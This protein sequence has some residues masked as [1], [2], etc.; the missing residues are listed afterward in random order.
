MGCGSSKPENVIE[1]SAQPSENSE[2][3]VQSSRNLKSSTS[4]R[5]N[6]KSA[7]NVREESNSYKLTYFDLSGRGELIR[8][9]FA[10]GNIN[11]EDNRVKFEEWPQIKN[12]N[13][14]YI[15]I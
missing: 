5:T 7:N 11:Y 8:L 10:A 14:F 9:V 13:F 12:C 2:N 3:R 15:T 1:P 6:S 4:V